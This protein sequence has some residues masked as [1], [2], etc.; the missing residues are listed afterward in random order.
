MS[1]LTYEKYV[2]VDKVALD[3]LNDGAEARLQGLEPLPSCDPS[4]FWIIWIQLVMCFQKHF[5]K[6]AC[7]RIIRGFAALE[8]VS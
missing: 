1:Y 5:G 2:Q 4:L 7:S 6:Q 3:A 8:K